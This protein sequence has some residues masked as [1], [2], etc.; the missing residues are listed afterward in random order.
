MIAAI[1]LA[2]GAQGVDGPRLA[3]SKGAPTHGYVLCQRCKV[4]DG[5]QPGRHGCVVGLC[6]V[7]APNSLANRLTMTLEMSQ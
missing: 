1:N 7:A 2:A 5:V 4:A 3:F 6:R